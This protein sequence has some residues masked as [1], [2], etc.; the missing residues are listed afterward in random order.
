MT[1]YNPPPNAKQL[2][3][4]SYLSQKPLAKIPTI[5]D[6]NALLIFYD[7]DESCFKHI[8]LKKLWEFT[9]NSVASTTSTA[10]DSQI[11]AL[12]VKIEKLE[13]EIKN[14]QIKP[15]Y[16]VRS[17]AAKNPRETKQSLA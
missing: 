17:K 12:C 8:D 10:N 7:Q 11:N 2:H 1:E 3:V 6:K 13:K 9:S 4:W 5:K 14:M 15:A 16:S